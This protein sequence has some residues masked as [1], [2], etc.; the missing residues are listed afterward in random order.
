MFIYLF[1]LQYG[2]EYKILLC[3]PPRRP[4]EAISLQ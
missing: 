2:I 4:Q 1:C 3:D